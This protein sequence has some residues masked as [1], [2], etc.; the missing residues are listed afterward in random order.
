MSSCAP[1]KNVKDYMLMDKEKVT[2]DLLV[3]GVRDVHAAHIAWARI[4][5]HSAHPASVADLRN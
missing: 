2:L 3:E 4:G 1:V 5:P